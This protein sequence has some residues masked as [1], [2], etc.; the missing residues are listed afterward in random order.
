[1]LRMTIA[2]GLAMVPV[3]IAAPAHAQ[4]GNEGERRVEIRCESWN[5]APAFCPVELRR[6]ADVDVARVLGGRCVEGR[7]WAWNRS[8]IQVSQGCR[9]VFAISSAGGGGDYPGGGRD[10]VTCES[11]NYKYR[12]CAL[13]EGGR[14]RI[15]RLIAGECVEGQSWGGRRGEVWVD[16]GCRAIFASG[17]GS[18][19]GGGVQ[20][21]TCESWN[22]RY[23]ECPVNGRRVELDSVIAGQCQ[24]NSGWGL[25]PRGIWVNKGC[26]ARF[27]VFN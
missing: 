9:A 6:R 17:R 24:Q 20:L 22:Y 12:A 4:Y 11:F 13:P 21:I 1:M 19:G 2:I 16:R 5:Y 27:R 3:T 7:S 26:R 15:V 10:T 14:P 25:A 18:G 8:G 23:A